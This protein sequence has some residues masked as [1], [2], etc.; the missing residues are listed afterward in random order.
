MSISSEL[1]RI[2]AAKESLKLA[3]NARGGT[4]GNE[5]ID[6]YASAVSALPSGGDIDLTGVTV[7][8]DKLLE[9]IVAVD[10]TGSKI[11]GTIQTV[12]AAVSGDN[13]VVPAGF[14]AEAKSFPVS[15][16]ADVSGVTVTASDMLKG[17]IAVGSD[18]QQIVGSIETVTASKSGDTVTVPAGFH[19]EEQTFDIG[20]AEIDL[21]FVTAG[22]NDILSGK[23]G[24][25]K[26]G[27][28][29]TG[30]IQTVSLQVSGNTVTIPAG[31]SGGET[32]VIP[33]ITITNDGEKIIVP[34]GYNKTAQ[35]FE[36]NSVT[37]GS[38]DFYKC[39]SVDTSAKTWTGYKAVLS[40]GIYSFE[41]T[42]TAGLSCNTVVPVPGKIYTADALA[43]I[44]YLFEGFPAISV[45]VPLSGDYSG[46]V[47]GN[48]IDVSSGANGNLSWGTFGD[49][50]SDTAGEFPL[51][52]DGES[53][54]DLN[55]VTTDALVGDF[56][57]CIGTCLINPDKRQGI[58]STT[59]GCHIAIDYYNGKY[60]LWVGSGDYWD[61]QADYNDGMGTYGGGSI[62]FKNAMP[63]HLVVTRK[64]K[65]WKL[66][67]DGVL[68]VTAEREIAIQAGKTL[69]LGMITP[70]YSEESFKAVGRMQKFRIYPEA[71][72]DNL[73]HSLRDIK[74]YLNGGP[75]DIYDAGTEVFWD[76]N[77]E[78]NNWYSTT[79][80]HDGWALA[81]I[82]EGINADG[83]LIRGPMLVSEDPYSCIMSKTS[84]AVS[85]EYY[86]KT[87]YCSSNW[88][89]NTV[90]NDH[91]H[92]WLDTFVNISTGAGKIEAATELLDRHFGRYAG[93]DLSDCNLY[94]TRAGM[95]GVNGKWV[96]NTTFGEN[97]GQYK[98]GT[99]H[100]GIREYGGYYYMYDITD[101]D[102]PLYGACV[103]DDAKGEYVPT[104][105]VTGPW[106]AMMAPNPPPKVIIGE[107]GI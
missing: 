49:R 63:V 28:P 39:A 73:V 102:T 80:T 93:P 20:G 86:G 101:P 18:G 71:V 23:I 15:G 91:G 16:G 13:V 24:A 70:P 12:T 106:I 89:W 48:S 75:Y 4:L 54:L 45:T 5:L 30:T 27:N 107:D 55:G 60:N 105:D 99:F 52:F 85:F 37:V 47:N 8:A 79:K 62:P 92:I 87:Y 83:T 68:S 42:P 51:V 25:D 96:L 81:G 65:V 66:F 67:V 2:K 35:E 97:Q 34:V 32:V 40:S 33:E 14:H 61:I 88:T 38:M 59:E 74:S 94:V 53:Y 29:V 84:T 1:S 36:I 7:T 10:V 72:D 104:A 3:I 76:S 56:T 64:G 22:A 95:D 26:E 57:L 21:D 103:W 19:A 50:L 6:E 31:F 90:Y 11:T 82:Y 98:K 17:K 44:E 77:G 43:V 58:L 41:K 100:I 78:A 69:R 46:T 9:G